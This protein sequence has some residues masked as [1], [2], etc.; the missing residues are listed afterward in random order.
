MKKEMEKVTA[1]ASTG[2]LEV[3][4]EKGQGHYQMMSL[5]IMGKRV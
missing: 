3:K 5:R 4:G 2:S 1:G